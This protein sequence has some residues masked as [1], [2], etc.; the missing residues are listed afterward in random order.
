[1]S[2][3]LAQFLELL[4]ARDTNAIASLLKQHPQLVDAK[5]EQGVSLLLM[6]TY[7]RN[8]E[9]KK[10][11]LDK[12]FSL[13]IF[14]AT[15]S[16]QMETVNKLLNQTPEL[17]EAFSPDGFTLLGL[18]AYF[19]QTAIVQLLLEKGASASQA[20]NNGMQIA[21]IHSAVAINSTEIVRL[22]LQYKVDVN[23]PQMQGVTALH[24]AVHRNNAEMIQLLIEHGANKQAKMDDGKTALDIATSEG[25]EQ[26]IPL[27]S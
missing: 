22:L 7:Y 25:H 13:D 23:A 15:A 9:V 14:E 26:L 16:G 5:T 3:P 27:L 4:K 11:I 12:K 2:L 8:E 18:A 24:S 10:L 19:G 17:L 20:S 21:P 1:M 6:A